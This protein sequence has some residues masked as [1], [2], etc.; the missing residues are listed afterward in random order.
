[1]SIEVEAAFFPGTM[2]EFEV[3]QDHAPLISSLS[4][5]AIR[6]RDGEGEHCIDIKSGFVN[7]RD[8]V[9]LACVEN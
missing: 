6:Y 3:L 5:G 2:G 1:M 4:A 7:V 8:N 9:I